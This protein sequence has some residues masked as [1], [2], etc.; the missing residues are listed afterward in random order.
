MERVSD[1]LGYCSYRWYVWIDYSKEA[2]FIIHIKLLQWWVFAFLLKTETIFTGI[3][4]TGAK[5]DVGKYYH[6]AF[7]ADNPIC[8]M[9]MA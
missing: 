3:P 2:K 6:L 9:I 1:T 8:V 7:G 5:P 4:L